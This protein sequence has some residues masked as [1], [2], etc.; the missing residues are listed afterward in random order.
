MHADKQTLRRVPAWISACTGSD[1][2][3]L[4]VNLWCGERS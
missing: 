3:M 2:E 4:I 1:A